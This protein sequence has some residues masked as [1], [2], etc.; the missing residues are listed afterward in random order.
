MSFERTRRSQVRY[1]GG[2]KLGTK[3]REAGRWILTQ[4]AWQ[5]SFKES[6]VL[7][8]EMNLHALKIFN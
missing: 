4:L 1:K 8:H 2:L 7:K 3:G 5:L 6:T